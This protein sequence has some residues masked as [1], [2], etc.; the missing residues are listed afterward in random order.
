M[1]KTLF[2]KN[3]GRRKSSVA[4]VNIVPGNGNIIINGKPLESYF[5]NNSMIIKLVSSPLLV[6]GVQGSFDILI[7]ASGGGIN[8]QAQA[9][10]LAISRV[11]YQLVARDS[12][13][14]LKSEG[15][16]SRDCRCKERKKYGLR[17]ARKAP[18]F[19]KR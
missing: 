7:K 11:L 15:F 17:K 5:Q 14:K 4:N 9:V 2:Y 16:L 19:S 10:K 13:L 8:G 12:S 3:V 1:E 6:L 18:Q